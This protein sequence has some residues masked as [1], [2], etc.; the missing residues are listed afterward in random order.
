M[1]IS[2]YL[3]LFQSLL[4]PIKL[5]K[6]KKLSFLFSLILFFKEIK[7]L[8]HIYLQNYNFNKKYNLINH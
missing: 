2:F 1:F 5:L 7:L 3:N 4:N 6:H 8:N